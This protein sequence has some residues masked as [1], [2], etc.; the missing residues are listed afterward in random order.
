MLHLE[1]LV[2]PKYVLFNVLDARPERFKANV[3]D[4]RRRRFPSRGRAFRLRA[5]D[6]AASH[7]RGGRLGGL[8]RSSEFCSA[9]GV[10]SPLA[11]CRRRRVGAQLRSTYAWLREWT[12]LDL[13]GRFRVYLTHPAIRQGCYLRERT[14]LW[15]LSD[16][17]NMNTVYFWHELLHG[18][19][20]GDDRAHALIE[21]LADNELRVRLNGGSYLPFVGHRA[22]DG[23]R[24][25]LLEARREHLKNGGDIRRLL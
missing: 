14:I 19:L 8:A 24:E 10:H 7:A 21:L 5:D 17:P 20:P 15:C 1:F 16:E 9:I 18:L 3:P 23:H 2:D 4:P 6:G 12:G 22:L 11:G 13:R 25:A